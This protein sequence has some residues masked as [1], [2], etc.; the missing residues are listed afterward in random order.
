MSANNINSD[1]T[2]ISLSTPGRTTD[3]P[4]HAHALKIA[5]Q[6]GP[7]LIGLGVIACFIIQAI[8]GVGSQV[9]PASA[10]FS[11]LQI[12]GLTGKAV[13]AG[14]VSALC[15]YRICELV[16]RYGFK[17]SSTSRKK[18]LAAIAEMF[19]NIERNKNA[20]TDVCE[21]QLLETLEKN[22]RDREAEIILDG[23]AELGID[24][25]P[26]MLLHILSMPPRQDT[27]NDN[28]EIGPFVSYLGTAVW[29]ILPPQDTPEAIV[30][31]NAVP[32]HAGK[33]AV[34]RDAWIEEAPPLQ[35][36]NLF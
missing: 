23:L 20:T 18:E 8:P 30:S 7:I 24:P 2:P 22:L 27:P 14:G 15:V 1:R 21:L 31:D 35:E 13:V 17:T 32:Q 29:F 12:L 11:P 33:R 25:T 26:Q 3:V 16:H 9:M 5:A 6:V 19:E 28:A 34:T 36:T 10:S 4:T